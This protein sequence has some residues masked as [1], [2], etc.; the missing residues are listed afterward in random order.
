MWITFDRQAKNAPMTSVTSKWYFTWEGQSKIENCRISIKYAFYEVCRWYF[1][2]T[3]NFNFQNSRS[4]VDCFG[5]FTIR[6][7]VGIP[8]QEQ[9]IRGYLQHRREKT[10]LK[11]EWKGS[12]IFCLDDC[13]WYELS[14]NDEGKITDQEIQRN[15]F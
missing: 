8:A 3:F 15:P 5:V 11:T 12:V 14:G 13:W 6:W 4:A 9:R 1:L 2:K 10:K 7:F